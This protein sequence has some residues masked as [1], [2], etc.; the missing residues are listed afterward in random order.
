MSSLAINVDCGVSGQ[1]SG[2]AS[3][4]L[5][6]HS[7]GRRLS[8]AFTSTSSGVN[9]CN[10]GVDKG[11]EAQT[12][13]AGGT[14]AIDLSAFTNTN[15]DSGQSLTIVRQIYVEH[16]A[17]SI[18]SAI[19]VFNAGAGN[20]FQG[21]VS[22]GASVSLKPGDVMLLASQSAGG[23]VVDATHKNFDITN[24]D[25]ANAATIRYS[26]HGS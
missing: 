10:N 23:W 9:L 18:A 26:I 3:D 25:G 12:L 2:S 24:S 7:I 1:A 20:S 8:F 17:G 6:R 5:R 16:V 19:T 21:P 13:G 22:A 4:A 15:G 14:V 11:S